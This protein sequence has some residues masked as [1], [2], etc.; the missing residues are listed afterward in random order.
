MDTESYYAT[1][2]ELV[3]D[4]LGQIITDVL[5]QEDIGEQ[6]SQ[7]LSQLCKV[8]HPL[9]DIFIEGEKVRVLVSCRWAPPLTRATDPQNHVGHFVPKWFKL[10]YLSEILE[11]SMVSPPQT[12]LL[13]SHANPTH[14]QV[15]IMYLFD[16]GTLIDFNK[17]EMIGLVRALFAESATRQKN[18]EKIRAAA[19]AL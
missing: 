14:V 1:L 11:G 5:A 10:L 19:P 6:E 13:H 4:T 12:C 9:Q 17:D 16:E 2:G 8:L 3:N 7:N 15:D 18:I